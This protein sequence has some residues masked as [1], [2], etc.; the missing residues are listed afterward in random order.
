MALEPDF[1]ADIDSA[2]DAGVAEA[3]EGLVSAGADDSLDAANTSTVDGKANEGVEAEGS[4]VVSA[5]D[6]DEEVDGEGTAEV[7][8]E[9]AEPPALPS[10][11][12]E[13]AVRAG[14]ALDDVQ[15]F[16]SAKA[17]DAVCG[18][19]EAKSAVAEEQRADPLDALANLDPDEYEPEVIEMFGTLTQEIRAQREKIDALQSGHEQYA[20]AGQEAAK[21]EVV[22]W[23]DSQIE[24]LGD[25]YA[26]ALGKGAH[27]SLV[28]GSPQLVKREAIAECTEILMAGYRATGRPVPSRDDIFAQAASSVLSSEAAGVRDRKVQKSLAKRSGQHIARGAD[29]RGKEVSTKSPSD[30]VASMLD[31]KYF[32]KG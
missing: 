16:K 25:D 11:L 20:R 21:R 12:I 6:G 22:Q 24:K 4:S 28:P 9:P 14:L 32:G 23:F 13:R 18:A 31:A 1:V 27:S 19:L 2:I 7:I 29:A 15:T 30:E 3:N 26:E 17:L 10:I 5:G 8:T